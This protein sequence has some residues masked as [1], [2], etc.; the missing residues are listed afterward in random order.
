MK[1]KVTSGYLCKDC[2]KPFILHEKEMDWYK[3]R[4]WELPKRCPECRKK[5]RKPKVS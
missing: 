4:G 3:N 1:D 5:R 2:G